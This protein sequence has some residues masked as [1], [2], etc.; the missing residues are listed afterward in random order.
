MKTKK[1]NV[2]GTM[3][4]TSCDGLDIAYCSFWRENKVWKY[5]L[6]K[7]EFEPYTNTLNKKLLE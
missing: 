2:I 5:S 6:N 1:F 3:S 4:G 7:S